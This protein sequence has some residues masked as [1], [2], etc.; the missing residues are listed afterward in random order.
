MDNVTN[1]DNRYAREIILLYYNRME[2]YPS[3]SSM[4][5]D[6]YKKIVK[7]KTPI[8]LRIIA[9][10]ITVTHLILIFTYFYVIL[11]SSDLKTLY[12]VLFGCFILYELSI[13]FKGCILSNYEKINTDIIPSLSEFFCYIVAGNT[14]LC[15]DPKKFE[16]FIVSVGIAMP[17]VKIFGIYLLDNI[18][19]KRYTCKLK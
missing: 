3:L 6:T 9:Y 2:T 16:V 17:L 1:I 14:N 4:T 12:L 15:K 18:T 19:G 8:S 5:K 11:Y 7:G 13:Y 10:L